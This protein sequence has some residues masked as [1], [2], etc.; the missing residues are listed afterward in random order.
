M[1]KNIKNITA[2]SCKIFFYHHRQHSII[3][4][5]YPTLTMKILLP[6]C[7]GSGMFSDI[8][9]NRLDELVQTA[10]SQHPGMGI[11]MLKGYLQSKGFRIQ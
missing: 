6:H 7:F 9:D 11:R 3:T 5:H 10:S 8:E 1:Y 2:G 4:I